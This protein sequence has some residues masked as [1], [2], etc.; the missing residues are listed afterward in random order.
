[1]LLPRALTLPRPLPRISKAPVFW[2]FVSLFLALLFVSEA[3]SKADDAYNVIKYDY[4]VGEAPRLPRSDFPAFYAGAQAVRT[5][6]PAALY[7]M[8]A[9]VRNVLRAQGHPPASIPANPD[10]EESHYAWLR[11]YN[12]PFYLLALSPLTLLDLH[13]AYL[14]MIVANI[15]LLGGL[16][17]VLGFILRWRQPLT[18]L[19][20]LGLIGF[21]PV[22]FTIHH[23]QPTILIAILMS[24]AYLALRAGRPRLAACLLAFVGAKPHWLF[25][26]FALT[27]RRPR[28]LAI[29]SLTCVVVL[30]LPF[31]LLGTKGIVDYIALV[32]A[33]GAGDLNDPVYGTALLSWS[34]FF[35]ALT[36]ESQPELWFGASAATIGCFLLILR[37]GNTEMLFAGAVL[38]M[39]LV[40]PHSHPQDWVLIAPV[41]AILLAKS[42][43]R[44]A[45][46]GIAAGLLAIF[47]GA[48][49]WLAAQR[50]MD[51]TGSS[52]YWITVAGF[53]LLAWLTAVTW[54]RELAMLLKPLLHYLPPEVRAFGS[55]KVAISSRSQ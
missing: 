50:R 41:A 23:A 16:M 7:D 27:W 12:P 54:S 42:P 1:M 44:I 13:T 39:L 3:W 45:E 35:R 5:E 4:Y 9:M 2:T 10:P 6:N 34:G 30:V 55:E 46:L 49:D 52:V 38:T 36:G 48:N 25:A 31:A 14:V 8:E 15:V 28:V 40:V 53:G 17:V 33:R 24:S 32:S 11:Y 18:S 22:Y 37:R 19:L 20:A 51:E 21:S 43:W 29:L 26:A 47:L